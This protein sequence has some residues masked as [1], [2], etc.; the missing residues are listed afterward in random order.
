[1]YLKRLEILLHIEICTQKE[2]YKDDVICELI[3]HILH[4]KERMQCCLSLHIE[5]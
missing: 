4:A 3:F 2:E 1:M 5:L